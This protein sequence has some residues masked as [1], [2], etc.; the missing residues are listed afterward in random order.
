MRPTH[1]LVVFGV[2]MVVAIIRIY[3]I[4]TTEVRIEQATG[5][6]MPGQPPSKGNYRGDGGRIASNL[7]G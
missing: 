5:A 3:Q 1:M 2:M 4:L 7:R 6:S